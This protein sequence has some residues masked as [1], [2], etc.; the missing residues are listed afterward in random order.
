MIWLILSILCSSLIFVVFKLFDRFNVSN[1]QAIIV[2]YFVAFIVGW[3]TNGFT[4]SIAELPKK[5]WIQS[6]VV[7]GFLFIF[8]FQ[9][10]ALVAQ[11]FG[12]A[13]VSVI[14]KMSLVIPVSIGIWYYGD[15]LSF[16]KVMGIMAALAAVYFATLKPG[17]RNGGG[18]SF[19]LP[20]I[21]FLGGG[22]LDSFLKYNQQELVPSDEHSYF[23]S[24]I[25]LMAGTLGFLLFIIKYSR[26]LEKVHW[27]NLIAGIAL[28]IPNY[29]SIYFLL[30]SLEVKG[31]E[32]SV[33]FPINNVGIV[34]VSVITGWV[35]FNEKLSRVNKF[36][37]IL[38]VLAIV[39]IAF[40]KIV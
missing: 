5:P 13:T 12:V 8:L 11:K 40:E 25:F 26:G 15:S 20:V 14:V 23:A 3:T 27:R 10:M 1:L 16:T 39:L 34:A 9:L 36:G 24:L 37:I 35:L 29:G 17:K 38:A 28:G 21:L 7:L 31:L 2:N 6:V 18:R 19:L 33:I 32:S 22:F 4:V 30:K